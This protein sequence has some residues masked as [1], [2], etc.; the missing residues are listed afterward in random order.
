MFFFRK[1]F[2]KTSIFT[3]MSF[4]AERCGSGCMIHKFVNSYTL[5][6]E[7]VIVNAIDPQCKKRNAISVHNSAD[8]MRTQCSWRNA[9]TMQLTECVHNAADGMH[10]Q[11]SWRNAYT[12]QLTSSIFLMSRISKEGFNCLNENYLKKLLCT[13][14]FLLPSS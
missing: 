14:S 2:V 7:T 9:Y 4:G 3:S 11:C 1:R 10:K 12:M 8:G 5:I 6:K 13:L